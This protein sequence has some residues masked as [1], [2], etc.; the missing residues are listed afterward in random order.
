MATFGQMFLNQG[1][2]G[3]VRVLSRAAV[4]EMTRNQVAGLSAQY[5]DEH[6]PEATWG[7][8]WNVHGDKRAFGEGSL[9]SPQAFYQGNAG[10]PIVWVDPTYELVGVYFSTALQL[11]EEEWPGD[12]F[13]NAVTAAV[14]D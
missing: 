8:G 2:Y 7:I 12:L 4:S 3:D 14:E 6:I 10:G 5:R 1:R 9:Q 13:I 11:I